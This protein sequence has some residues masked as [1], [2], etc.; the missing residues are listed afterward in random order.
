MAGRRFIQGSGN[1]YAVYWGG[2]V[3]VVK[4]GVGKKEINRAKQAGE[5]IATDGNDMIITFASGVYLH[6]THVF[7][8]ARQNGDAQHVVVTARDL[9]YHA[10][11]DAYERTGF[12]SLNG[13]YCNFLF[14]D[15]CTSATKIDHGVA[16]VY[17]A[18][19]SF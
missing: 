11:V 17:D 19:N 13:N 8:D 10:T 4:L 7:N 12:L 2:A 3:A 16:A 15:W 14:D 18:V 1:V 6:E 9:A 5:L